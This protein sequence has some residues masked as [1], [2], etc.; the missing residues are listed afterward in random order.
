MFGDLIDKIVERNAQR[1]HSADEVAAL[2]AKG[3]MTGDI[4]QSGD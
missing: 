4:L 2:F 1:F 3:L